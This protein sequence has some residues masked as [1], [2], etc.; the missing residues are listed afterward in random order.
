M[1]TAADL[2]DDYAGLLR[3]LAAERDHNDSRREAGKCDGKSRCI[4]CGMLQKADDVD[5]EASNLRLELVP[6]LAL[7]PDNQRFEQALRL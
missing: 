7:S 1:K 3:Y 2:L 4:R 6:A 5:R